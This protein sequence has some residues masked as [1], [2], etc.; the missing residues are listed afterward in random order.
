MQLSTGFKPFPRGP[1][2][3]PDVKKFFSLKRL[4]GFLI[5]LSATEE[6]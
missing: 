5:A 2:L 4:I 6:L 3:K 1:P